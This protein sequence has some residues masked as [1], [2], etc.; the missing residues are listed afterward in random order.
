MK[1]KNKKIG[2][3]KSALFQAWLA[4]ILRRGY[5]EGYA[6]SSSVDFYEA[7]D[8]LVSSEEFYYEEE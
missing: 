5:C 7:M 8:D 6:G 2:I 1:R 3:S 4:E